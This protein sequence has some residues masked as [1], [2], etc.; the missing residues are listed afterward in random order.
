MRKSKEYF[1]NLLSHAFIYADSDAIFNFKIIWY[2]LRKA[3]F[4]ICR[5]NLKSA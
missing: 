2:A 5:K 4:E 1:R 3:T